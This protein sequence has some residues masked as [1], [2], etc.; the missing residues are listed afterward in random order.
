MPC[1]SSTRLAPF[2]VLVLLGS[3]ATARPQAPAPQRP[4]ASPT[5]IVDELLACATVSE[6]G[7]AQLRRC[8]AVGVLLLAERAA[9]PGRWDTPAGRA[10]NFLRG[11]EPSAE[12]GGEDILPLL[13][14]SDERVRVWCALAMANVVPPVVDVLLREIGSADRDRR[15]AALR[16]ARGFVE[17][18]ARVAPAL[19]GLVAD[20]DAEVRRA[21]AWSL[22]GLAPSSLPALFRALA[23]EDPQVRVLAAEGIEKS[24]YPCFTDR[25]RMDW[26]GFSTWHGLP[27]E[28][29]LRE[30]SNAIVRR[31]GVPFLARALE[32][33]EEDVRIF[34]AVALCKLGPDAAA[35]RQALEAASR[36]AAPAV[37]FWAAHALERCDPDPWRQLKLLQ[38]VLTAG[39]Q[40]APQP[41]EEEVARLARELDLAAEWSPGEGERVW[42]DAPDARFEAVRTLAARAL[43][44]LLAQ[45]AA[46][47][48]ARASSA[49]GVLAAMQRELDARIEKLVLILDEE[50]GDGGP[51]ARALVALGPVAMP[52][53]EFELLRFPRFPMGTPTY[54]ELA[55]VLVQIG[56][57]AVPA[58]ALGLEHWR[59]EGRVYSAQSLLQL[60]PRAEPALPCIVS[61]WRSVGDDVRVPGT[62]WTWDAGAARVYDECSGPASTDALSRLGV[63]ALPRLLRA[64]DDPH[65]S[66]RARAA[67]GLG[68]F[69]REAALALDALSRR[70]GD[71][72]RW[73]A[74]CAADAVLRIAPEDSPAWRGARERRAALGAK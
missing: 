3:T 58:L 16:A 13:R 36:D 35:G 19:A 52:A 18:H 29:G 50:M 5:Q 72:Q 12:A 25:T 68:G 62:G 69:G 57:P 30:E 64:L 44:G 74:L 20:A 9:E 71:G 51:A 27:P 33:P 7:R 41:G 40:A 14:H 65:A 1:A 56:E 61:A 37:R 38:R 47:D 48:A 42:S 39:Q 11:F 26:A 60:G 54:A 67:A 8:G 2:V 45:A 15:L 70:L 22:A 32:D 59:E 43:D 63:R 10:R 23:S 55:W 73:V 21:A 24:F 17:H 46:S 34:A 66:V 53:L 6:E 4:G 31:D 49:R 28:M